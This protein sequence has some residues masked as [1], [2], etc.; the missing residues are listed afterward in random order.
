MEFLSPAESFKL[1]GCYLEITSNCN[2]R[3]L[4]CYNESGV[5][6]SQIDKP[7]FMNIINALPEDPDTSIT[8]SVGEPTRHTDCWDFIDEMHKKPFGL[9]LVIT[10]G[11]CIRK[12]VGEK[13]ASYEV[14]HK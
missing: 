13:V 5:L 4:H 6:Q 2:L 10:K 7:T 8:I 11:T 9:V 3:C 14:A 1:G 12:E